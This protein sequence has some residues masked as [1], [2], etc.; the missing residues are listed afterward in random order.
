MV[1]GGDKGWEAHEGRKTSNNEGR[2]WSKEASWKSCHVSR[3]LS[4]VNEHLQWA[5]Y[6]RTHQSP[7]VHMGLAYSG[8]WGGQEPIAITTG[9]AAQGKK[10]IFYS[11]GQGKSLKGL[12][13]AMQWSDLPDTCKIAKCWVEGCRRQEQ[14][15][16]FC[17][18]ATQHTVCFQRG[19]CSTLPSF[20]SWMNRE[21]CY[22]RIWPNLNTHLQTN[23]GRVDLQRRSFNLH[24]WPLFKFSLSIFLPPSSIVH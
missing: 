12:D 15:W 24:M 13:G 22:V 2:V 21:V 11:N 4:D 14:S 9:L 23:G 1:P 5:A 7:E 20:G 3:D 18:E 10:L 19:F 6:R 17:Q 16:G 8:Q